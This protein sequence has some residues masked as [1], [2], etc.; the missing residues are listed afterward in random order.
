MFSTDDARRLRE[1]LQ[2]A[3]Y[4][5]AG[6]AARLGPVATAAAAR[7]DFRAALR[8]TMDG[9]RLD[10]LIRLFVCAQT[11]P[12][13]AVTEALAPLP[14]AAARAAGLVVPSGEG[15]R[16]GLDLEPYADE[17][18]VLADLPASAH[19]G[20]PVAP[21]HV[22]GVGGASATLAGA[23]TRRPV[24]AALDLGTGCG[25]QAL[26]L[27]RHAATV[28]A[29]DVSERA[30][31]FAAAN[32]A[33]NDLAWELLAGDLVAPVAGRRFDLVVSNPPF[34][35]GPG[36]STY[37]YRDSGRVGDGVS[38]E[39]A[40]A[41]PDLLTEGGVLQY[42]ANWAHVTGEDW[43]DRVAGW[44]AGTGLDAWV[45][46][47]E[48]ADPLSYVDLWLSDAGEPADPL[49]KAAWLDWFDAHKVEAVG[50]G[51]VTLRRGGA[52]DPVVRIEDLRQQVE[53]LLGGHVA[54]WFDRQDWL[55]GRDAEALLAARYR[56]ADGL[57][58]R[59]EATLGPEGW[60]VDRQVLAMPHGLRWT[61]E[62]DP[63]VLA[64]VGGCDGQVPMRDQIAVLA[65][66][67]EVAEAELADAAVPILAH[68][69]ERGILVVE[70]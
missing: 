12:V 34:V 9:D 25:V 66:A 18:W 56:A 6:I 57:R 31:R 70:Q 41:A 48:V 60:A 7:N 21:D 55:R 19:P 42:L 59:Q 47:R 22:L 62:T 36:E 26:H 61:E 8:S 53:G 11:E 20:R 5:S 65:V 52:A 23:T 54:A 28:T 63:L 4:T 51:L 38:A 40:A 1:A 17:W 13:A 58:L 39:L 50:F 43:A 68:L 37:A 46:Q 67:H 3:G 30:L 15:L 10:T 64:L 14:L 69:V 33:L 32:A 2:T 24:G 45:V 29:T 44:F 49:R 35:V 16:Q 27:S